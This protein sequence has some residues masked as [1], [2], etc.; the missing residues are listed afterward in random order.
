MPDT[1]LTLNE[2]KAIALDA[3]VNWCWNTETHLT[4]AR[5]LK[6]E[7]DANLRQYRAYV[8]IRTLV[9]ELKR[10][11]PD[12]A[13]TVGEAWYIDADAFLGAIPEPD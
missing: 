11:E 13:E 2:R 3:L 12:T 7:R 6:K 5:A 1:A 4:A 10:A 9:R 8:L